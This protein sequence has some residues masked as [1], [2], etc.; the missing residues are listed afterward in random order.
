MTTTTLICTNCIFVFRYESKLSSSWQR[1][2]SSSV[3][4]QK[5]N[6]RHTQNPWGIKS[7][8]TDQASLEE[9][10]DDFH[11]YTRVCMFECVCELVSRWVCGSAYVCVLLHVDNCS[12]SLFGLSFIMTQF[13]WDSLQKRL[14]AI[15]RAILLL[16]QLRFD[17][18]YCDRF[19]FIA[20]CTA[21]VG[22][23]TSSF[24]VATR[25]PL[26]WAPPRD[27]WTNSCFPS[28]SLSTLLRPF[29]SR[30]ANFTSH[31]ERSQQVS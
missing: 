29:L 6:W 26:N 24:T 1:T 9:C 15:Y 7:L 17:A 11:L 31:R 19:S 30:D 23:W 20:T 13:K 25:R 4:H 21:T 27:S 18:I 28:F 2:L 5:T 8:M 3:A 14:N 22:S 12:P 10:V 16:L